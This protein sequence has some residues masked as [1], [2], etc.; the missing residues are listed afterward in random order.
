MKIRFIKQVVFKDMHGTV[1]KT[2]NIGDV[3]EYTAKAGH[4][5]VTGMGGIY[6]NEAVEIPDH[7]L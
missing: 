3:V 2:Y 1:L 7:T 5:W 4:Y 6:F